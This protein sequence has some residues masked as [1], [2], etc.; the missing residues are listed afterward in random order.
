MTLY[1]RYVPLI[2]PSLCPPQK[3]P[4][5][6]E[7]KKER[8]EKIQIGIGGALGGAAVTLIGL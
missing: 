7:E 1:L 2:P 4:L 3:R 8:R 6:E 5:T